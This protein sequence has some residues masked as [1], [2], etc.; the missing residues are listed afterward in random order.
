MG[1]VDDELVVLLDHPVDAV[2]VRSAATTDGAPMSSQPRRNSPASVTSAHSGCSWAISSAAKRRQQPL[3][4][5][6]D[7]AA[8]CELQ[9][10]AALWPG[11]PRRSPSP[12]QG[13][14]CEPR[15][16]R[17]APTHRQ[18]NFRPK[19][20]RPNGPGNG[21]FDTRRSPARLHAGC[22]MPTCL[23]EKPR[24]FSRKAPRN[25]PASTQ[26]RPRTT[27][28]NPTRRSMPDHELSV[29]STSELGLVALTSARLTQYQRSGYL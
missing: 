10:L 18:N 22:S 6:G 3:D 13:V 28:P 16:I 12:P 4:G 23:V 14:C 1:D 21:R 19:P 8:R 24:Y 9:G 17:T 27:F 5:H 11:M 26:Q 29:L 7:P 15:R 2:K 25:R 20:P